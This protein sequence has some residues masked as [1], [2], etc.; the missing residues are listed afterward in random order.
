ML[1]DG[2]HTRENICGSELL[3]IK[4]IKSLLFGTVL[5]TLPYRES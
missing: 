4:S 5:G 2:Q 1:L 3:M